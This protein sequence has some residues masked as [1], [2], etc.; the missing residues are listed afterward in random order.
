MK[1]DGVGLY[2]WLQHFEKRPEKRYISD[3]NPD[4][5]AIP[6]SEKENIDQS[7]LKG[8]ELIIYN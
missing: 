2:D 4:T 5:M 3:G 6:E 7:K 8:K 1:T